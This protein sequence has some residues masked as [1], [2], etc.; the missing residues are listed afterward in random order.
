MGHV[1][2]LTPGFMSSMRPILENKALRATV[3][4]ES[5]PGSPRL[6]PLIVVPK[7][8]APPPPVIQK[9]R[10]SSLN[11][12]PPVAEPSQLP[13]MGSPL[14]PATAPPLIR[15]PVAKG[16]VV[17]IKPSVIANRS[18]S[19]LLE[20]IQ[21]IPQADDEPLDEPPRPLSGR[22]APISMIE[23]ARRNVKSRIRA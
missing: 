23:H 22:P 2:G 9:A 5:A 11:P 19:R 16:L 8:S 1:A 21:P 6:Q 15:A 17:P 14:D 10:L 18:P 3:I 20:G 12:A 13:P 4:R 7:P